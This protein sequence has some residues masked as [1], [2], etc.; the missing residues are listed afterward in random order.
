MFHDI[1]N[2]DTPGGVSDSDASVNLLGSPKQQSY[3]VKLLKPMPNSHTSHNSAIQ[4]MMN[5]SVERLDI[6]EQ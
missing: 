6:N 5:M 1:H 2:P 4:D 3:S